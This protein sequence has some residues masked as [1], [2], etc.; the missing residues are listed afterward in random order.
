LIAIGVIAIAWYAWKSPSIPIAWVLT[1]LAIVGVGLSLAMSG[2]AATASPQWLTRPSLFLHGVVAA[3]WIGALAP[4]AAMAHRRK[5][6]LPRVL[7]QFSGLA[8]PL[9]GFLVLSG[10]VLSIIQLG[11]VSALIE[12]PYGIIL[13]IKL[14]LVILLLG[15]AALNRFLF[16]PAVIADYENARPLLWS[17][18]LECVLVVGILAVVAGWRFTPPPRASVTPAAAPLSVH[19]HTDAAMFQ[20][21]VSPGRVGANDFVLQLMTGDAALLPAKEATLILSLPERGIEPMERRATLGP[22]GYWH[23]RGVALPLAGRWHMQI[24]ALVTDFQKI[25]LEDDLQVR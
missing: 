9:V 12:T 25:T 21:L 18:L 14:S 8:V 1:T 13:S 24:D 2:H 6:D 19:I 5:D 20:V 4:M 7:K 15:L 10:L 23:V 11:S 22:D 17:I 3:Y 16:T